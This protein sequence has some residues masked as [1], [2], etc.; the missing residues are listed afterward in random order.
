MKILS[1]YFLAIGTFFL[2]TYMM[3][4]ISKI[5]KN[6][7]GGAAKIFLVFIVGIAFICSGAVV[8]LKSPF[9]LKNLSQATRNTLKHKS[10]NSAQQNSNRINTQKPVT[11]FD[12]AGSVR[13][14]VYYP[15]LKS[16]GDKGERIYTDA[17]NTKTYVDGAYTVVMLPEG[18]RASITDDD[19]ASVYLPEKGYRNRKRMYTDYN[20]S[21]SKIDGAIYVDILKG[22]TFDDQYH[23]GGKTSEQIQS[24]AADD[25]RA[26]MSYIDY[27]YSKWPL[28]KPKKIVDNPLLVGNWKYESKDLLDNTHTLIQMSYSKDGFVTID[29]SLINGLPGM[30]KYKLEP[31]GKN[32]YKLYL[33]P[34][35]VKADSNGGGTFVASDPIKRNF[36]VYMNSKDSFDLVFFDDKLQRRDLKMQRN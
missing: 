23:V 26:K 5:T 25:S 33:Y 24:F 16:W 28:Q 36:L 29:T 34:T 3:M 22:V 32:T 31:L 1:Y 8:Y 18:M 2:I 19:G 17:D 4:T 14:K 27:I 11:G 21:I 30:A 13:P 35:T 15:L 12:S 7:K 10:E 20:Y 6:K 9:F